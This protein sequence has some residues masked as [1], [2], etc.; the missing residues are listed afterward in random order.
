MSI[1]STRFLVQRSGVIRNFFKVAISQNDASIYIIPYANEGKYYG[2]ISNLPK[3]DL[4][5]LQQKVD[6]NYTEQIADEKMPKLSIHESGQIHLDIGSKRTLPHKIPPLE[7]IEDKHIASVSTDVIEALPIFQ[8]D[9]KDSST[10]KD[11]VINV[12][13]QIPSV[14]VAIYVNG[15]SAK[16]KY[17][18]A[19]LSVGTD[20]RPHLKRPISFGFQF[21]PQ[22]DI[23]VDSKGAPGIV[24]ISGWDIT[25]P[26]TEENSFIFLRGE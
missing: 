17:Q 16:F 10:H 21:I 2:G 7:N 26:H 19:V 24:A 20:V 14:R 6:V 22:G 3:I 9:I 1:K 8:A 25:K 18:N 4:G 5:T 12:D 23:R 11:I 15:I 13:K